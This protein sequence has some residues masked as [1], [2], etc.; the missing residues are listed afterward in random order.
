VS[1]LK[2]HSYYESLRNSNSRWLP[3]SSWRGVRQHTFSLGNTRKYQE[4]L[5][6]FRKYLE[7]SGNTCIFQEILGN[8]R[9]YYEIQDQKHE[10]LGSI[11][12]KT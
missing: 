9:K 5:K 12:L 10:I 8:I 6:N 3:C 7:I 2:L 11:S 4:I 1:N